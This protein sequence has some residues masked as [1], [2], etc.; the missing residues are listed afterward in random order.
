MVGTEGER[1]RERKT[2]ADGGKKVREMILVAPFVSQELNLSPLC[3]SLI[4]QILACFAGS[5]FTF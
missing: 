4:H 1:G 2:E 3:V 5:I